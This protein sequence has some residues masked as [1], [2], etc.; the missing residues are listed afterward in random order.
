MLAALAVSV[1]IAAIQPAG[2]LADYN[3]NYCGIPTDPMAHCASDPPYTGAYTD[4]WTFNAV[5]YQGAGTVSVC[6]LADAGG[7]GGGYVFSR[8]CNN[9]STNSNPD[10][11]TYVPGVGPSTD[12]YM[13]IIAG[14]NSSYKHTI[15]AQAVN[16]YLFS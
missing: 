10:L 13:Y 7:A 16:V 8:H 11:P 5:Q 14:N 12:V 9:G 4:G 3:Y 15:V 1:G 2:A 6:E